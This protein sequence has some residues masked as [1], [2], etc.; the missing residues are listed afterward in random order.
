MNTL[1]LRRIL[2]A[3]SCVP[4]KFR[5]HKQPTVIYNATI[6]VA[7]R[8]HDFGGAMIIQVGMKARHRFGARRGMYACFAALLLPAPVLG[9]PSI[10]AG[11][12]MPGFD[13]RNFSLPRPSPR[14][15]QE[16]CLAEEGCKAWTYVRPELYGVARAAC[17]L[18]WRVPDE[19]ANACCSSGVR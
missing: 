1:R 9:Q 10:K 7:L 5:L 15:C 17:W 12:D 3:A 18:K 13:Y 8:P 19:Q 16:A 11:I 6:I 2:L 14:L 4:T